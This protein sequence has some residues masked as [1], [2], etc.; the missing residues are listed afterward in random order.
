M[1]ERRDRRGLAQPVALEHL[2]A[3]PLLEAAQDLDRHRRAARHADLQRRRVVALG[4]RNVEDRRV[5]RRHALEDRHPIALDDLECLDGVEARDQREHPAAE[6]RR[7]EPAGL[8]EGV[9]Q[10]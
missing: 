10:R 7:V 1:V 8:P 9:K 5:H 3:E 6:Q 2:A 4:I